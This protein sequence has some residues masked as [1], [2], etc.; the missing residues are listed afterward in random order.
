MKKTPTKPTPAKKEPTK[1][2]HAV[3]IAIPT[4][5][6]NAI[7]HAADQMCRTQADTMRLCMEIGLRV[8]RNANYDQAGSIIGAA[9]TARPELVRPVPTELRERRSK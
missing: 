6:L 2:L 8:L 9:Q 7:R 4:D 1:R 5:L 3:P